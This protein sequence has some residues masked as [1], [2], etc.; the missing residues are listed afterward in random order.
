MRKRVIWP[1]WHRTLCVEMKRPLTIVALA[2]LV[3]TAAFA[4]SYLLAQR[5][6]ARHI[7]RTDSLEWLHQEFRLG[8]A[9]MV[10][11]RE[12]HDGYLP[13]CAEMCV[14]IAA[15]KQ[16][17]EQ[18]LTGQ[19][20]LTNEAERYLSELGVLR[21]Q[22]QTEMLRH[23]VEVSQ[24]MPPEQGKR[25][26]TEMQRLTLGFHEQIEQSMSHDGHVHHGNH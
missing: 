4:G 20:N 14:R 22:C 12:L 23:F 15:K 6:C 26:L 19:T 10:R 3:M 11:V 5:F 13:K 7:A 1:R 17:L 24:A 2:L 25:Y 18:A 9:D 8:E 16:E 21:T